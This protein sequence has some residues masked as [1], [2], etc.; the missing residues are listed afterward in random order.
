MNIQLQA[1]IATLHGDVEPAP[2]LERAEFFSL[3]EGVPGSYEWFADIAY[4]DLARAIGQSVA[5]AKEYSFVDT[6]R[7]ILN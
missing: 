2:S 1:N 6:T 7:R 4:L 3:Y 5:N